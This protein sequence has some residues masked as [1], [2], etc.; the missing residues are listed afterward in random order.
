MSGGRGLWLWVGL[1]MMLLWVVAPRAYGQACITCRTEKCATKAT[2]ALWCGAGPDPLAAPAP[3]VAP[4]VAPVV[5]VPKP[6]RPVVR[7]QPEEEKVKV[8]PPPVEPEPT[9]VELQPAPV[10]VKP[11][12]LLAPVPIVPQPVVVVAPSKRH[13]LRIAKWS[14]LGGGVVLGA[15]GAALLALDGKGSCA[16]QGE[17]TQC[18]EVYDTRAAGIGLLSGGVLSLAGAAVVFGLDARA[19]RAESAEKVALLAVGGRF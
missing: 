18:R 16:L 14:L 13:P 4:V 15:V 6:R 17:M 5:K 12:P 8:E 3:A 2:L 10:V 19:A 11:P 9:P 1:V 7:P